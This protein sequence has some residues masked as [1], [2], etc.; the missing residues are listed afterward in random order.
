[1]VA[2][3]TRL[4][5]FIL[6]SVSAR[7]VT[8]VYSVNLSDWPA[9]MVTSM[10]KS[11]PALASNQLTSEQLNVILKE[12]DSQ[13]QFNSLRLIKGSSPGELRLVGEIS[14]QIEAIEFKGLEELSDGEA[15]VLMNLNLKSAIEEDFVKSALD[16][17]LQF[18]Q[19][20]GYRFATVNYNYQVISTFKRNLIITVDTK[21][22]T[23][24]SEVTIDNID[25]IAQSSIYHRMNALF[26]NEFLNQET[27]AKM[28]TK[29]RQLLSEAGYFLTPVPAAQLVFSADEL[30]ARAVFRLEKKQKYAIEIIGANEFSSSYLHDDILKL[31]TYFSSDS[32][33]GAELSEK[34]KT[35]YRT[36]GWP[37]INVPY[38]ERK[39]GNKI[40][41]VLSL[42]EGGFTRLR[43][44]QFIGQ[45]SRPGRFY[46]KKINELSAIKVNR[47]FVKEEIEAAAKNLLTFLQNEGFVNARLGLLQIYTDRE[48]STEGIAVIQIYEGEQVDIGSLEYIGNSTFSSSVL[49]QEMGLEVGQKLNLRDLEEAA[50]KLKA[51]YANAGYIE[52]KLVNEATD[53]IQYANKNTV[54][55]LKFSI[56]EGPRVEVQSILIEGNSTTHEKVILT[57]IDF[58]PGDIL[59]PAKLEESIARLQRTGHFSDSQIITLESG[60]SIAARTVIIRVIERDPGVFTIGAGLTNENQGNLHGYTGLA[61]RNIGGWGRGLSGRV[62][63]NYAYAD[64]K[65]LESKITFG[66]LEPYLFET[67]TRFRLNLTRS[68]TISNYT[69]RKV[70]ELNSTTFSLE[71]DF[72]SHIT[73]IL[74]LFNVAT[75]VD[76]I[77]DSTQREDLVIVSSGPTIDLDYRNNLFNPTDG[78]FSRLSFEYAF[79]GGSS[80][81]D[82][83]IRLTGQ[84]TFY[85]P[86]KTTDFVF[87][88]SFRGG[89]IQDI[90]QLGFGIPFDKKGFSLGGRTTIRGFDSDE[91]FPSDSTIGSSFKLTS[92]ASYELIKSELRFPLVKKWDLMGALFYD[93]GQV[94][95]D[96]ITFEDRWRDAIG[97][98][99]RY[100]T[101]VGPLNLEYAKKLDKKP[102]ENAEAFH[103]SIGVF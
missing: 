101:P 82:Q 94:L 3:F 1:M 71:Q 93:G 78:S 75:Y 38:F 80:H 20:Q 83:F 64:V 96:G 52:F 18:Y 102:T 23:R 14:A 65:F 24:I 79:E 19:E 22:Q 37:H 15:L 60:T 44:L 74:T 40:T 39:D 54:A 95:I 99:L 87:A 45:L 63:G 4:V 91:F 89:Y 31:N 42:E 72:T 58:K 76:R 17:L 55:H 103:L 62:E 88:Q 16:K 11:V 25:P 92:H 8:T 9:D 28:A 21:K 2:F 66:F 46:E 68:T 5:L 48:N 34:L 57:E 67:R 56:Q 10:R 32:N 41:V 27:L 50:N 73:G 84:T 61:Y 43:Q 13:F 59:T 85:M 26:K 47:K 100:N 12:L 29:L 33:F 6:I 98:G 70:T 81:I 7:A 36:E 77:I 90:N 86:V 97:I 35:F 49:S 51:Y 53:L 30:K 69:L